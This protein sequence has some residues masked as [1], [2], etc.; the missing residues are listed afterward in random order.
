VT[1]SSSLRHVEAIEQVLRNLLDNAGKYAGNGADPTIH[2]EVSTA[3]GAL[4]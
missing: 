3:N 2:L 1:V 4:T